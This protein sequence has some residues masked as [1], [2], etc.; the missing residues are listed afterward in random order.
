MVSAALTREILALGSQGGDDV[1][2]PPFSKIVVWRQATV[3]RGLYVSRQRRDGKGI[4]RRKLM[5]VVGTD[6]QVVVALHPPA[7]LANYTKRRTTHL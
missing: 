1:P 2:I 6:V 3:Y 5:P 4:G 7:T